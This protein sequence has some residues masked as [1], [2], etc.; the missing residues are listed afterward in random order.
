[1]CSASSPSPL[2]V[3]SCS[4]GKS[5]Q[6]VLLEAR[7]DAHDGES[8]VWWL[9]Y[10]IGRRREEGSCARWGGGDGTGIPAVSQQEAEEALHRC[11]L[12]WRKRTRFRLRVNGAERLETSFFSEL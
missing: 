8:A 12:V 9:P 2:D 3:S 1:M 11:C 6:Q 5:L 10:E 4:H 7:S